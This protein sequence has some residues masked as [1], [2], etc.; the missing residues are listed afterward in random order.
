M[1]V[2]WREFRVTMDAHRSADY[3]PEPLY[4]YVHIVGVT[5]GVSLPDVVTMGQV[6]KHS[7][8]CKLL[9]ILGLERRS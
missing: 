9:H 8:T 3:S 5:S 2:Y 1:T 6:G 7:V 4:N